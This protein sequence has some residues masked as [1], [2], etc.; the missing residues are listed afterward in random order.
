[1]AHHIPKIT[2]GA[3]DT[4][5]LFPYPPIGLPQ[6]EHDDTVEHTLKSLSGRRQVNVDFIQVSRKLRFGGLSE[7]QIASIRTFMRSWAL[8]GEQFKFYDDQN[9]SDFEIY[10][11]AD[12][13]FKPRRTS[14]AGENAYLYEFEIAMER[15]EDEDQMDYTE[16]TIANAQTAATLTGL[17]LDSTS[18]KSVRIFGELRRKTDSSEVVKNGWLVA[19]YKD[20]TAAWEITEEL[21]GEGDDVGVTFAMDGSQVEYTSSNQTGGNYTG[22][23]KIKEVR[24]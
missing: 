14:I 15:V 5:F 17:L 24:F 8:K 20:S 22:T 21:Q 18:Y 9:G 11:L 19:V 10:E 16:L 4:A 7:A 1:M 23:F 13:K 3:L 12:L 2:Y 6:P